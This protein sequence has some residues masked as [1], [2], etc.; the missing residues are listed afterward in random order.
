MEELQARGSGGR[1]GLASSCS[2]SA[3][4]E[5]HPAAAHGGQQVAQLGA[6][7]VEG[8]AVDGLPVPL[9]QPAHSRGG[10]EAGGGGWQAAGGGGGCGCGCGT[11]SAAQAMPACPIHPPGRLGK[12]PAAVGAHGG[13]SPVDCFWTFGRLAT[14][15]PTP[16]RRR[17]QH[18]ESAA[19]ASAAWPGRP[20]ATCGRRWRRCGG[21]GCCQLAGALWA[22]VVWSHAS[23]RT[24]QPT[25]TRRGPGTAA[26][27]QRAALRSN[28]Q[29]SL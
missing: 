8:A 7:V 11:P 6:Q 22:A 21:G 5:A 29:P 10:R 20:H 1:W 3:T 19:I 12:G 4:Q 26:S 23:P 16:C 25:T 9:L 24:W 17:C 14:A 27:G 28:W 15:A 18:K 13:G 2:G